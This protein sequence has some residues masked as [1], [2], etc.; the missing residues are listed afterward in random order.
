MADRSARVVLVLAM[1]L[2]LL[3]TTILHNTQTQADSLFYPFVIPPGQ[4]CSYSFTIPQEGGGVTQ[5]MVLID[6]NAVVNVTLVDVS[7]NQTV[8][9]RITQGFYSVVPLPPGNYT[10]FI[11]DV[12][13][14]TASGDLY[15]V[16]LPAPVGIADYG[17]KVAGNSVEPYVEK[18]TTV[19]GI[20]E[21]YSYSVP[22]LYNHSSSLQLN[23]V[24]HINTVWGSQDLW[25]Q[26]V[27]DLC[28]DGNEM[29]YTFVDNI[30]NITTPDASVHESYV[31]GSG[32]IQME[33]GFPII[34][35]YAYSTQTYSSE[36]PLEIVL[37]INVK[38]EQGHAVVQFGYYNTTIHTFVWY[39]NVTVTVPGFESAYL[40]VDGYNATRSSNSSLG[41]LIQEYFGR[42]YDT[43]LVFAGQSNG[44]TVSFGGLNASLELLYYNGTFF[45]PKAVFP[46]GLDTAEQAYNLETMPGNG[47]YEVTTGYT[48]EIPM[49]L[50]Q[51]L[52]L[53]IINYTGVVDKGQEVKVGVS[54]SGAEGPYTLVTSFEGRNYSTVAFTPGTYYFTL[55]ANMTG[56]QELVI[57]AYTITG[58][59]VSKEVTVTVNPR[60]SVSVIPAYQ[61]NLLVNV[62]SVTLSASVN[63]GTPPYT[64]YA[65][66]N[67]KEVYSGSSLQGLKLNVSTGTN[68]V[69]VEVVDGLGVRAVYT[70]T[71][72]SSYNY[73][74]IGGFVSLVVL[75]VVIASV[76]I[77]KKRRK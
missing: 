65:F 23:T 20:A 14:S 61:G 39:D 63:G 45:Y 69:T 8:F 31:K 70:L 4:E 17:V 60:P 66:L 49:Y 32:G 73:T 42:A 76:F 22:S 33:F 74:V 59:N 75:I 2:A 30:W 68:N 21:I 19:Y 53:N 50:T 12:G 3:S 62:T 25:L 37:A 13:Y 7:D 46:F 52:S 5:V 24:L 36:L 56:E 51:L 10:L 47:A 58:Q 16:F 41:I 77:I 29:N 40:L 11:T 43:E 57:Y 27:V 35:F 34:G 9:S 28:G 1:T 72:T 67:G 26:D 55:P 15:I 64:F 48:L 6:S 44:E 71:V 54:V 38:S 18:F